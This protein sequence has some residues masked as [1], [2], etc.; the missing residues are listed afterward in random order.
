MTTAGLRRMAV[1]ESRVRLLEALADLVGCHQ[2]LP[3][4]LPDGAR[5]DVLRVGH[6]VHFLFVG[7]A[8]HTETPG[9]KATAARLFTYLHW[10]L[11]FVARPG[12]LGMLALCVSRTHSDRSWLTIGRALAADLGIKLSHC[13]FTA[14]DPETA[15]VWFVS[16][17]RM[18][19]LLA[20]ANAASKLASPRRRRL[21]IPG[22]RPDQRSAAVAGSA[23]TVR[24]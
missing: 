10:L 24:S 5:P 20:V 15:I 2:R 11:A 16:T 19:S 9:N 23:R 8:K 4:T 6:H 3:S 22:S 14:L 12:A 7:D 1:H 18:V 21:R 13:D 17:N